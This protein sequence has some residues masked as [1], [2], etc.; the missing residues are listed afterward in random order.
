MA[1]PVDKGQDDADILPSVAVVA[2]DTNLCS[3]HHR[4]R[5]GALVGVCTVVVAPLASLAVGVE[6]IL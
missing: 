5:S 2:E 3:V 4:H 1:R 6:R